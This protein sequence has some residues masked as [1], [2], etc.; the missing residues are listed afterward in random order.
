MLNLK[1]TDTIKLGGKNY[2]IFLNDVIWKTV[3][4][5]YKQIKYW[6]ITLQYWQKTNYV[7]ENE[8]K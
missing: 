8:R 6:Q 1:K 3:V 2:S 4:Y 7:V 5:F